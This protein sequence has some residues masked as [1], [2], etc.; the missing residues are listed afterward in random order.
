MEPSKEPLNGMSL[1]E[2]YRLAIGEGLTANEAGAKYNCNPKS[3]LKIGCKYRLPKLANPYYKKVREQVSK[4]ND[5]QLLSYSHALNLPKNA[6]SS[7]MEKEVVLG[8][9]VARGL[10]QTASQNL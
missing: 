6:D 9:L 3:L 7:V 5:Q 10:S 4:M 1:R 8:E 2:I